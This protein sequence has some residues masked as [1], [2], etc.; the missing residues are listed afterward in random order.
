MKKLF[1]VFLC[2]YASV[3]SAGVENLASVSNISASGRHS[4]DYDAKY[5]ADGKIPAARI[6]GDNRQA[7]CLPQNVSKNAWISFHSI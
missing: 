3:L 5:V 4:A 7:W 2:L 1:A 6:G